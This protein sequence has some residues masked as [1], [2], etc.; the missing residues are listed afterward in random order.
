LIRCDEIRIKEVEDLLIA[1]FLEM[2]PVTRSYEGYTITVVKWNDG[3]FRVELVHGQTSRD[4]GVRV[5]VHTWI[6]YKEKIKYKTYY[7]YR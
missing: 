2:F 6:W 5:P 4:N 3:T 7:V 1:K